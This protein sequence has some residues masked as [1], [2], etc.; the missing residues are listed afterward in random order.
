MSTDRDV[1]V[2][3]QDTRNAALQWTKVALRGGYTE[4]H[5]PL[6]LVATDRWGAAPDDFRVIRV[7]PVTGDAARDE[8]ALLDVRAALLDSDALKLR[9]MLGDLERAHILTDLDIDGAWISEHYEAE[10]DRLRAEAV[11]ITE[12]NQPA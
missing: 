4:E 9:A 7:L 2:I 8:A 6:R 5:I 1:Q 11:R 3:Y 10:A 12:R